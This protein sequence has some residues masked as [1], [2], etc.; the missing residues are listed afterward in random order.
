MRV[1]DGLEGASMEAGGSFDKAQMSNILS[2]VGK[3]VFLMH[4]VH[5][6]APLIFQTRWV[7]S[8]LAGPM[9]RQQI[10]QLIEGRDSGA[11]APAT[12]AAAAP[13]PATAA[14]N[15]D[16]PGFN[17]HPPVLPPQIT[18]LFLPVSKPASQL[19]YLP[20][21]LGLAK[22]HFQD[23]RRNLDADED[24]TLLLDLQEGP[25]GLDWSEAEELAISASDI[26][27]KMRTEAPFATLPANAGQAGNYSGWQKALDDWLYRTRRYSIFRSE[28]ADAYSQ[29][30]ESER[31]FRVRITEATRER[32][33]QQ[34][35]ELRKKYATKIERLEERIRK[36]E[37]V[38]AREQEQASAAKWQ[39][40]I[41]IGATIFSVL[42]G[43]K[44]LS[45]ITLGKATTAARGVG[46]A[47]SQSADVERAEAD[48]QAYQEQLAEL[49]KELEQEVDSIEDRYD[50]Q[51][52]QLESYELK[53]RRVDV[54]VHNVA[55]A[56]AP[57]ERRATGELVPLY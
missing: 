38:V 41:S 44:K 49:Q 2:A 16:L 3:R 4:N 50:P 19:V 31:E 21:L 25:T 53:P 34:L 17:S 47:A 13:V 9:T 8:Y 15:A 45:Q 12:A 18:Q 56:W 54:Q 35:D 33:D 22:V 6:S 57:H 32:R 52:E 36:S 27:T 30:D 37:Q 26:D 46:R 55:L 29:P 24:L 1:L 28:L 23:K 48:L 42:M 20:R 5:D 40:I 10:K 39:G 43:R 14:V 7:M 11:P 51:A